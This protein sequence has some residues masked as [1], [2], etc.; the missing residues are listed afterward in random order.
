MSEN[1]KQIHLAAHFPGV[2]NTTVWSDPASGSQ[3]DFSSFVHLARTAERAKFDF[4]FLA[5]GLRLREQNGQIYD[6]DVVGRPDTFTVLAALA[7]VTDKLGLAGTINSTF[8]E[9]YEV[10]RQFATLDHL[11]AGRAAWN[12]VTS[13]DEFTGENFRRG[14]YLAQPD[15]YERARQ[16][17]AATQVLFDSWR[18]DE[19]VADQGSGV[20]LGDPDAGAFDHHVSQFDITGQF[21]VPRSPQGRPVI[22]Q[23]GDS[24]EGREFAASA[25]DA[26]FTRHGTLEAGRAFYADVKGRLAR[27][28][29]SPDELKIL[30]GVTFVLGATD[31]EARERAHVI[32]HQ[33]VSGQTAIK[34]LEQLW[35]RD[36][37]GYDPDGP[38]PSVDPLAGENTVAR[39]RASVRMHRDPLATAAE[40]RALA[41]A[42][43]L[44]I[45]EL[46][47]EVSGRQSFIGTPA[48]VAASLNEFVQTDASDGFILVP[49]LTPGGLDEF[50][51]TVVPLL[52]ERGV[53]R[54]EYAG[55][56]LRDHLG[57]GAPR[58][59]RDGAVV[60]R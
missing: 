58:G 43:Q 53:F 52:Q 51:D 21:N 48:A 16:F 8:N 2:N 1:A 35:N 17:L 38:L 34:L 60:T 49:H 40:W 12:V 22:F 6:L 47:I 28:G 25:A 57:L 11:S 55:D 56:T 10:A 9:P 44:S 36:L 46:I 15:R 5:E 32:R 31:A 7:A 20:F 23:A 37:S 4:L 13:W 42:K 33:Q 26:I 50:A 59:P 45:R 18:G 39:G 54:T 27:Y 14:G 29:R 3:I 24:E 41:E 30:P 19:V